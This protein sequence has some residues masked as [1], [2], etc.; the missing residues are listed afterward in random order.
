[1]QHMWKVYVGI[2]VVGGV[3]ALGSVGVYQSQQEKKAMA[4]AIA[5]FQE[6]IG[7]YTSLQKPR[8]GDIRDGK[9][10]RKMI[11]IDMINRKVD[12][13]YFQLPQEL[14]ATTPEE[15]ETVVWLRWGQD[16]IASYEGG[17]KAIRHTCTVTVFDRATKK[18]VA[19]TTFQGEEPPDV[20]YTS[21][22]EDD[23]GGKPTDKILFYLRNIAGL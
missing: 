11:T 4:A 5:P 23:D 22:G 17:G 13:L 9:A 7:E 8:D 1:M 21:A 15:V 18:V 2:A 14:R 3:I 16:Y 20:T 6:N 10:K 19:Q 12:S